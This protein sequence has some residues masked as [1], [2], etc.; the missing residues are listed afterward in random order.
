MKHEVRLA[1]LEVRAGEGDFEPVPVSQR[2]L[3]ALRLPRLSKLIFVV[4]VA[5][6]T[7]LGIEYA[8]TMILGEVP[9]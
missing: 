5:W 9:R 4:N 3:L 7:F 1:S 8:F 6:A 2:V